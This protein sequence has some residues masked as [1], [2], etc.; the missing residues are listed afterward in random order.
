MERSQGPEGGVKLCCLCAQ[1]LRPASA[2]PFIHK[3]GPTGA[4][5]L[6]CAGPKRGRQK[7]LT[8]S[9]CRGPGIS[10]KVCRGQQESILGPWW[11]GQSPPES[12][13]PP[14]QQEGWLGWRPA[15]SQQGAGPTPLLWVSTL[16]RAQLTCTDTP[17]QAQVSYPHSPEEHGG[18][19]R[20]ERQEVLKGLGESEG[21]LKDAGRSPKEQR[22]TSEKCLV[23]CAKQRCEHQ[24]GRQGHGGAWA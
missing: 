13:G 11:K 5:F 2:P 4:S 8:L 23:C 17:P 24:P 9:A 3:R 14:E 1:S 21:V 15:L 7:M 6:L 10:A 22:Q 19:Q 20:G 16:P 18:G 12:P